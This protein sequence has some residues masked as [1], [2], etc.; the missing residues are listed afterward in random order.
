MFAF[1]VYSSGIEMFCNPKVAGA[2]DIAQASGDGLLFQT[3]C[4]NVK[5]SLR[6]A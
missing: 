3:R 4:W 1:R 5:T 2:W 6:Q